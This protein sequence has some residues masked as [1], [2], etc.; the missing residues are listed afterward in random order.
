MV[1]IGIGM[2]VSALVLGAGPLA[3]GVVLGVLF[4][5]LGAARFHLAGPA[6]ERR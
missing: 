2:V 4:A 6:R 3:Y 5:A 1:V